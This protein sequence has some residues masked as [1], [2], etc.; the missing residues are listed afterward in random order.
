MFL[1]VGKSMATRDNL[2]KAA[3][4]NCSQAFHDSL[5]ILISYPIRLAGVV[6]FQ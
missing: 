3:Q 2:I 6:A 1:C 5:A 4:T